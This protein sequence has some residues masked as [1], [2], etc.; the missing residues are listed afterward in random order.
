MS[1]LR[2]Y[3]GKTEGVEPPRELLRGAV[4]SASAATPSP[5][6]CA[7]EIVH[8]SQVQHYRADFDT[9]TGGQSLIA[10]CDPDTGDPVSPSDVTQDTLTEIEQ[11]LRDRLGAGYLA[12]MGVSDALRVDDD[13]KPRVLPKELERPET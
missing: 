9:S 6:F 1:E 3:H 4:E 2:I 12:V 10:L 11:T 13:G 8:H 7:G 5:A